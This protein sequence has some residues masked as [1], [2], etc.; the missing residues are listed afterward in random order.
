MD[1]VFLLQYSLHRILFVAVPVLMLV[2]IGL[3]VIRSLK[4]W[5][6]NEKSPRLTVEAKIVGKRSDYRRT[7]SGKNHVHR[8]SRTNYF[9]TFE[10]ESGDRMELELRGHEYGLL[11]EG[12]RGRLTFQGTRYL[13]F[14]RM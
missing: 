3:A 4:E 11:V 5:H 14:E 2:I 8:H 1:P 13:G 12:D 6:H 9:V 7:M 10:V